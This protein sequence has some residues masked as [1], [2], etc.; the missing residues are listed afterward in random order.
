MKIQTKCSSICRSKG[1]GSLGVENLEIKNKCVLSKWL[2]KLLNEDVIWQELLRNKY[3]HSKKLTQVTTKPL[4]SPFWK[5]IMRVKE[6]LFSR[7][8][9]H[10]QL[11]ASWRKPRLATPCFVN[12]THRY[13]I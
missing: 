5:G 10:W 7:A 11:H 12:N 1:Q 2:F 9:F 13:T 8:F 6:E 3:I 4:D